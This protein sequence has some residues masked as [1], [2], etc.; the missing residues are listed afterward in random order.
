[1]KKIFY[2]LGF[3][4][5]IT[6]TACHKKSPTTFELKHEI[7][8]RIKA[9]NFPDKTFNVL[10]FGATGNGTEDA[11]PAFDSTIMACTEAGGGLVLVPPGTYFLEG[12]IHLESNM[13]LHLDEGAVLKFSSNAASYPNVFT[14]W[15]G[16]LLYNYSPF[17]YAYKK[18]NVAI[19]GKG[20]IDGESANTFSTWHGLQK[21]DQLLS[22]EMNHDKI[23]VDQ[24][25]FGE[26][27]YLRPQLIQ[28][29]ECKNILVEDVMIEDSPFWCL[30][31]LQ[32][33]NATLRGLRYNA[34]NKNN[35]GIDIEYTS[36]VLI[37]NVEFDNSDDNVAIKAGR[38]REGRGMHMPSKNIIVRNC[39]FKGLHAIVAGS[40]MSSGV[41]DVYVDSCDAKGYVKRGIYLKSNPDRGGEISNIYVS[42]VQFNKVLDCFMVTS[43][44]HNEGEGFPVNIQNIH[45]NNVTCEEAENYGIYI[46]GYPTKP[47][48]EFYI[49]DFNVKKASRGVFVDYAFDVYFDDVYVNNER[50]TWRPRV[51]KENPINA[52]DY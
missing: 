44:Y 30:H 42:N 31:L 52:Y 33:H 32:C 13:N 51:L 22:R 48:S 20:V 26:G 34:H 35:D 17:I 23:P 50:I 39:H 6:V 28:F 4:S 46:K 3:V 19:T 24:R 21:D 47:V 9:P 15:E 41:H 1:M 29:F 5:L 49:Q 40:E 37:E 36:D 43:N 11:K 2:V 8:A 27:H 7:L 12:P 10:D 25:I 38:D 18:E 14:S 45:V 16:T